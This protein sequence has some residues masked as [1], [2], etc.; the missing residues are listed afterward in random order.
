MFVKFALHQDGAGG[1]LNTALLA[2]GKITHAE[3]QRCKTINNGEVPLTVLSAV[4]NTKTYRA[5]SEKP[6]FAYT[7]GVFLLRVILIFF[8]MDMS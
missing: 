6:H 2:L 4:T 3:T 7:E 5:L 1:I 8:D